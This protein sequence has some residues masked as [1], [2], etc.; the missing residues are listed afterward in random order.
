MLLKLLALYFGA[1]D[2][3]VAERVR[4]ADPPALETW[5][6][7]LVAAATLDAVFES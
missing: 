3:R 2:E 4:A 6:E 5:L 1:L 7:R